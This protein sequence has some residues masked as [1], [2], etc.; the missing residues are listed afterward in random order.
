MGKIHRFPDRLRA[1]RL[2]RGL[3]QKAIAD[4]VGC[5]KQAVTHWE[6][7]TR[8]PGITELCQIADLLQTDL[9]SLVGRIATAHPP[10]KGGKTMTDDREQLWNEIIYLRTTM[11][12]LLELLAT[13]QVYHSAEFNRLVQKHRQ[14]VAQQLGRTV[15]SWETSGEFPGEAKEQNTT[16]SA[17]DP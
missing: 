15:A 5:R 1:M 7:G 2:Q 4:V 16:E 3:T 17:V 6:A 12:A 13:K 14:R 8:E 9:D 11:G 10:A